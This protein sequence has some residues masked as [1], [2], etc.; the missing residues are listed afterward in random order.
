MLHKMR[1]LTWLGCL[2]LLCSAST[3]RS[4]SDISEAFVSEL[5]KPDARVLKAAKLGLEQYR[6]T[7]PYKNEWLIQIDE[8]KGVIETNWFPEHKGEVRLKVQIVVWGGSFRVD[9]W[10]KVGWLF[11]SI[12]KTDG[13][14]RTERHIQ[15]TIKTQLTTG[16]P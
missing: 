5:P 9:V 11:S 10:Q 4:D 15:D 1:S 13:S 14:R 2:F 3:A 12:E 8:E 6:D 16:T 7:R